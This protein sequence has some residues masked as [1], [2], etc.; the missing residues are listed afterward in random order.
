MPQIAPGAYTIKLAYDTKTDLGTLTSSRTVY[1]DD[2]LYDKLCD[3]CI[4][5]AKSG[6]GARAL[7]ARNDLLSK[8]FRTSVKPGQ[9]LASDSGAKLNAGSYPGA[10]NLSAEFA[11]YPSDDYLRVTAD[12]TDASFSTDAPKDKPWEASCVEIMVCPGGTNDSIN[13]F[14]IVPEGQGGVPR[15]TA[16][17][18]DKGSDILASYKRTD[19]GYKIEAKIPWSIVR[20]YEKGW[21]VMPVE[22]MVD[23]KT[24]VGRAQIVMNEPGE[25]WRIAKTYAALMAR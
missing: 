14:F 25:P 22:A 3:A 23:S 5:A 4:K 6:D 10:G 13:Q 9:T 20:G 1:V 18:T 16:V 15:V 11:W 19:K 12:V 21:R 8:W 24:P 17:H 2:P 7:Q